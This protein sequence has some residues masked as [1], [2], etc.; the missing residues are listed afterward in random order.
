MICFAT[1]CDLSGDSAFAWDLPLVS[2]KSCLLGAGE[3]V[4]PED[5]GFEASADGVVWFGSVVDALAQGFRWFVSNLDTL[6]PWPDL[7]D[8]AGDL[9]PGNPVDLNG[10]PGDLGGVELANGI[11]GPDVADGLWA[12]GLDG[13]HKG[14][15]VVT[16]EVGPGGSLSPNLITGPEGP[17]NLAGHDAPVG[18]GGHCACRRIL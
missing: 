10:D 7:G 13:G 12:P 11:L 17:L 1:L 5:F 18:P 9:D 2:Q 6:S 3:T 8:T 14:L 4:E 16:A 15:G